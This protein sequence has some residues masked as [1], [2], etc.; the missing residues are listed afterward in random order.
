[1]SKE[2]ILIEAEQAIFDGDEEAA[3][4]VAKKVIS[5][6][7]NP[8][9]IINEGYTP[10][11]NRIGDLFDK[12]EIPLPAVLVAAEAMT[13]AIEILGPHIP[14]DAAVEKKGTIVLGTVEGDIHD[15]GK[16]IVAT[17][18]KVSGFD[19]ADLGRDVPIKA[20][21]EKTKELNADIV[22][23]SSLMTTTMG[24]Q[25][26]LE[27][28][29]RKAGIRDKVKTM[30]GGAATNTTWAEKIGA[31][32]YAEDSKEAVMKAKELMS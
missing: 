26:I 19:V 13:Q 22:G 15:I 11:M 5:E 4:A 14:K 10:G 30:V 29:L 12:E 21:V 8:I 1:M 6:G 16:R 3:L 27:E 18:M 23:S 28:E 7:L 9:D 31:D 24:G 25:R 32:G 20:F 2:A 17:M